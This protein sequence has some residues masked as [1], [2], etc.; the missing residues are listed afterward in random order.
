MIITLIL[1]FTLIIIGIW[2]MLINK[3]LFK[4]VIGFSIL[5]TGTHIVIVSVGYLK[6]RTAPIIDD[7]VGIA[8][9]SAKVID[10]IPSALV[11]TAIVIGLAVTA[12]M[13][14]YIVRMHKNKGSL[15]IEEYLEPD[16]SSD[17]IN[18][19]CYEQLNP[20]DDNNTEKSGMSKAGEKL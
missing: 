14:T 8:G 20:T 12:L 19:D 3:N 9:A 10:P 15:C 2:G 6:N 18:Q 17:R 1:G 16:K 13:L 4:I 5:D 11:L 7:A